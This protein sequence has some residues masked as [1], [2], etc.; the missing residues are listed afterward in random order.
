MNVPI[1]L[2]V[3][4]SSR[5]GSSNRQIVDYL[6]SRYEDVVRI[7]IYD[8]VDSLPPFDPG[9]DPEDAPV[10]VREWIEKIHQSDAVIV[11]TPEYVFSLPGMLKNAL[12]WTVATTVFTDKPVAFIVASASG[13]YAMAALAIILQT[14]RGRPVPAAQQVLVK[15]ARGKIA[16]GAGLTDAATA[17]DLDQLVRSLLKEITGGGEASIEK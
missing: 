13:E 16:A 8:Q 2:A 6:Q 11:C 5:Q 7:E 10:A 3:M 17:A 15:G 9:T 12:E 1:V 4:G 14:L